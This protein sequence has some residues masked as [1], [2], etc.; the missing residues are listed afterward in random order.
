M[1]QGGVVKKKKKYGVREGLSNS[2]PAHRG[3]RYLKSLSAVINIYS[4]H[5]SNLFENAYH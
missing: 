4:S 5:C 2:N 1:R 3:E